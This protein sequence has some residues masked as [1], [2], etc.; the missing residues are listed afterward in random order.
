M[1]FV[2]LPWH[3]EESLPMRSWDAGIHLLQLLAQQLREVRSGNF[4]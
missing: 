1:V 4:D 3:R 2:H